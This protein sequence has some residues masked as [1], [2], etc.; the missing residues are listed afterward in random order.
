MNAQIKITGGEAPAPF[1]A[2]VLR[3]QICDDVYA[4]F[5]RL[6]KRIAQRIESRK[7]QIQHDHEKL[8]ADAFLAKYRGWRFVR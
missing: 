7:D 2:E 4:R 8:S 5:W 1:L 3:G 6:R